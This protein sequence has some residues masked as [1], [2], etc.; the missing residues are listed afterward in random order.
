MVFSLGKGL[1]GGRRRRQRGGASGVASNAA[2]VQGGA[3][4]STVDYHSA[5]GYAMKTLGTGNQQWANTFNIQGG[6]SSSSN[7]IRGLNGQMAG[8]GKRR[9]GRGSKKIILGGRPKALTRK[10]GG[11]GFGS[12]L[13]QAVPPF[14]LLAMQQSYQPSSSSSSS[15]NRR[16]S[17]SSSSSRRR[18]SRGSRRQNQGYMV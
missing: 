4:D 16:R 18:G 15:K 11:F 2:P 10:R 8:G 5:S 14:T 7:A 1:Y 9:G 12:I 3:S 13:S 6:D 17:S